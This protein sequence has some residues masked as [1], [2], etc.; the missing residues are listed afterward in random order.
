MR[1]AIQPS[2]QPAYILSTLNPADAHLLSSQRDETA[3]RQ[4]NPDK[5][6]NHKLTPEAA[7]LVDN[8]SKLVGQLFIFRLDGAQVV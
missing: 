2:E 3:E 7:E 6:Y 8:P 1:E 5:V 4:F